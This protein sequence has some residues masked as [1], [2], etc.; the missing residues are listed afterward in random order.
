MESDPFENLGT[1]KVFYRLVLDHTTPKEISSDLKIK[2]PTVVEHL[3]RLQS[4]GIV[5]IG[6]KKGKYQHYRI[7]W[8]RFISAFLEHAPTLEDYEVMLEV[9]PD[10]VEKEK[11]ME[12]D[13]KR[14]IRFFKK[15]SKE[16]EENEYF[17]KLIKGYFK[18]L[19]DLVEL[20]ILKLTLYGA[21]G[22]FEEALRSVPLIKKGIRNA[23]LS[24][25]FY[26]LEKWDKCG[27]GFR[28]YTPRVVFEDT[29]K[30]L[31]EKKP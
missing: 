9:G 26:L 7:N 3:R 6:K 8:K 12:E 22:E 14:E 30:D 2:P 21:V 17:K 5:E 27:E 24:R 13:I 4:T 19:A 23:K 11:E 29:I 1:S 28:W 15:I 16:L 25:L 18:G 10:F 20:G 31:K